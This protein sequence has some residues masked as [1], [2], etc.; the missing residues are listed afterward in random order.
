MAFKTQR[1]PAEAL[2]DAKTLA[3]TVKAHAQSRVTL[4]SSPV[5]RAVVLSLVQILHNW[6][7]EFE[8]IALI[9]GIAQY[10]RDQFDDQ[11][12]DIVAEFQAMV[13]AMD[14]VITNIT[15]TFPKSD[16]G[17][18]EDRVLNSNGTITQRTFTA[19][20]LSTLRGLLETLVAAID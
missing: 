18:I 17:E 4:F 1:T 19:A 3:A 2:R 6:R 20:Q 12:Y 5:E 9:P 11:D 15:S 7:A 14:D 8:A 10:A 13:G 16:S